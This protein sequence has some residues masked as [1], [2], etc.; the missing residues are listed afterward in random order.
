MKEAI[1]K[2]SDISKAKKAAAADMISKQKFDE[3][4]IDEYMDSFDFADDLKDFDFDQKS[5][6]KFV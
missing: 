1:E 5:Y 3:S 4:K 2:S 6:I